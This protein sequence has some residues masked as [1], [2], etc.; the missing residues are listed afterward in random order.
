M[1]TT[2]SHTPLL[3]FFDAA[4]TPLLVQKRKHQFY[5]ATLIIYL[6]TQCWNL[7]QCPL[8]PELR[9]LYATIIFLCCLL[10]VLTLRATSHLFRSV[11]FRH[12][13]FLSV[14][15]SQSKTTI[16]PACAPGTYGDLTAASAA[17]RHVR[18]H[19]HHQLPTEPSAMHFR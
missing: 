11:T 17:V 8:S 13:L 4:F 2:T 14:S 19:I 10:N 12:N 6:T 7:L 16:G 3:R 18:A 9:S 5:V 1:E 15:I